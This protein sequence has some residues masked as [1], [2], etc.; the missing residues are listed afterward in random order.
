ISA[1]TR[2]CLNGG[3][4]AFS[5]W[6]D[7]SVGVE[8]AL[9]VPESDVSLAATFGPTGQE[10][11]LPVEDGLVAW[12]R[13]DVG[14]SVAGGVVTG[15]QDQSGYGNDMVGAGQPQLVA[16]AINGFASIRLDGI[17][18]RVE[19]VAPDS[20]A[21]LPGGNADRTM[22]AIVKYNGG[23]FGGLTYGSAGCNEVFGLSVTPDGKLM[24][25]GWCGGNDFFSNT[26]G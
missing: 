23:G 12:Y 11:E 3:E 1:A 24:I 19:R 18:D 4:Y 2:F 9:V 7:G 14:V 22:F 26:A 20:L 16:G 5:T 8:R 6:S 17:D 25:H 10:C 15:W 13:S 21:Q